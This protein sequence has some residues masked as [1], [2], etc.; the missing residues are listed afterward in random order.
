MYDETEEAEPQD[1]GDTKI[2]HASCKPSFVEEYDPTDD[3]KIDFEKYMLDVTP[4]EKEKLETSKVKTP[5]PNKIT[6]A[7]P[8]ATTLVFTRAD[9]EKVI[10]QL[11]DELTRIDDKDDDDDAMVTLRKRK[12]KGK[13]PARKSLCINKG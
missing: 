13:K 12:M 10:N 8:I 9:Q 5:T 1:A 7:K 2:N 11:I 6:T 4:I 3:K